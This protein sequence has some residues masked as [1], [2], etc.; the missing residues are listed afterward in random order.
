VSPNGPHR[1]DRLT[2]LHQEHSIESRGRKVRQQIET[3]NCAVT[4]EDGACPRQEVPPLSTK[5]LFGERSE[6]TVSANRQ[7]ETGQ[8][9]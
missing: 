6:H 7:R 9:P 1:P 3:P 8:G 4:G 2:D 5:W